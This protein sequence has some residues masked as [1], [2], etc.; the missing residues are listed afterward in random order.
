MYGDRRKN[1]KIYKNKQ[2]YIN[3]PFESTKDVFLQLSSTSFHILEAL[4]DSLIIDDIKN[5]FLDVYM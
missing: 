2:L 5:V 3:H 1:R 4:Y